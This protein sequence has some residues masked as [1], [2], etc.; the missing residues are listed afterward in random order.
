MRQDPFSRLRA[1]SLSLALLAVTLLTATAAAADFTQHDTQF[2]PDLSITKQIAART[3]VFADLNGQ[4][5]DQAG[6][7]VNRIAGFGLTWGNRYLS[8][9]PY[10]RFISTLAAPDRHVIEHRAALDVTPFIHLRRWIV[11]DRSRVDIRWIEGALSERYRNRPQLEWPL[12]SRSR[13]VTPYAA[14]EISYDTRIHA[15]SRHRIY[16]GVKRNLS[17][18]I[19][20]DTYFMRQVDG[21]SH[22]GYLY[23]VGG[24]VRFLY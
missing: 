9:S 2:W 16:A 8:V 6:A 19:G 14:F 15:W 17:S 1:I 10:Y 12:G 22:P 18:H 24:G 20:L 7:F 4:Y 11:S 3:G 21:H 5:G 13:P 23:V